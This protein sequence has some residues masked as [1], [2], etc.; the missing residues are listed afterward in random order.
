MFLVSLSERGELFVARN[1]N[2]FEL[3]VRVSNVLG[4]K[5][6]HGGNSRGRKYIRLVTAIHF[7]VSNCVGINRWKS[8]VYIS[9][10]RVRPL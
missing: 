4:V 5:Y 8:T 10:Q 2:D 6:C 3:P 9:K 7:E 1:C